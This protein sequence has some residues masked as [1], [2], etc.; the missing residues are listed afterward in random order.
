MSPSSITRFFNSKIKRDLQV[1]Q[2]L[3]GKVLH[4]RKITFRQNDGAKHFATHSLPRYLSSVAQAGTLYKQRC[5]KAPL[6]DR[7]LNLNELVRDRSKERHSSH[8]HLRFLPCTHMHRSSSMRH[9][10]S[11]AI[12]PG[13]LIAALLTTRPAYATWKR[14]FSICGTMN[15]TSLAYVAQWSDPD[16]LPALY[17]PSSFGEP[18]LNAKIAAGRSATTSMPTS[19]NLRHHLSHQNQRPLL[20]A[21][22]EPVFS[23]QYCCQEWLKV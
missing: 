10:I 16:Q 12:N 2:D 15:T 13:R 14:Q 9:Q 11:G 6:R 17:V 7:L 8:I 20:T 23:L 18:A 3:S 22:I 19:Y 5:V 4:H 1:E 21:K